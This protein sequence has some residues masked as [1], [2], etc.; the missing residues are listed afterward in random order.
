M[1]STN[2]RQLSSSTSD[3]PAAKRARLS[4]KTITDEKSQDHSD[5]N[6]ARVSGFPKI[7]TL[8]NEWVRASDTRNSMLGDPLIDWLEMH[9][10]KAGFIEDAKLPGYDQN[11][12][13]QEFI[14][15]QGTKFEENVMTRMREKFPNDLVTIQSNGAPFEMKETLEAMARGVPII[16]QGHI[17]E[18][19]FRVHGHPDLLVRSDYLNKLVECPVVSDRVEGCLFSPNWHYRTVDIKFATLRLKADLTTLLTQGSV[20]AFKAQVAIYNLCLQYMQKFA[21]SRAYL[22]G[23][24]WEGTK[25]GQTLYS[26]DPFSKLGVV[27]FASSDSE[28]TNEAIQSTLWIRMC[29][30]QGHEWKIFPAPSVPELYPNMTNDDSTG[31]DAAKKRIAAQLK[32]ITLLWQ[33]GL[34]ARQ[35]AHSQGIFSWDHPDLTAKILGVTGPKLGPTLDKILKANRSETT[36]KISNSFFK[37]RTPACEFFIDV[38]SVSSIRSIKSGAGNMVYLIGIGW[39]EDEKWSYTTFIAEKLDSDAEKDMVLKFLNFLRTQAGKCKKTIKLYHYAHA[40]Q[41]LLS[42]CFDRLQ[43]DKQS[44]AII[45]RI[46]WCDLYKIIRDEPVCI[47]GALDFSLKSIVSALSAQG[48]INVNYKDGHIKS[49]MG[50]FMAAIVAASQTNIPFSE[51]EL[52]RE[53]TKYNEV[54]CRALQEILFYF[55]REL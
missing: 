32:E 23:R 46:E 17:W 1:T 40:D 53:A 26:E 30:T 42:K 41:T 7:P 2:K 11:L 49:G 44:S 34:S 18:P 20:K 37:W 39:M 21:A 19:E 35:D 10:G 9:G 5:A 22:L 47:K 8:T 16:A 4:P 36:S 54:D 27:D 24:G 52:I 6:I 33:C 31:W 28:I 3:Q 14:L 43:L 51:H 50:G 45:N 38:E 48:K 25:K 15:Q 29:S 12:D 13:F 55:R